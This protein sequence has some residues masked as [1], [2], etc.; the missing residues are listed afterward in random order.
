MELGYLF[1]LEES[2][3][4]LCIPS[5]PVIFVSFSFSKFFL[6]LTALLVFCILLELL[7]LIPIVDHLVKF[8]GT[9][10]CFPSQS[11][12]P[13]LAHFKEQ[14][15][16]FVVR[17]PLHIDRVNKH[18]VIKKFKARDTFT[19]HQHLNFRPLRR[20]SVHPFSNLSSHTNKHK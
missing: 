8:G 4:Y 11:F 16:Y 10:Q 7:I 12:V 9:F 18:A 17:K 15:V 2:I 6:L 19:C 14:F 13:L 20:I 5:P 1:T 3:N